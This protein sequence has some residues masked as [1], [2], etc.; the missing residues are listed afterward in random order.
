MISSC[1]YK[2]LVTCCHQVAVDSFNCCL[3]ELSHPSPSSSVVPLSCQSVV[4]GHGTRYRNLSCFV[5]DGSGD[6]EGSLVDEELCSSLELAV[7][8]DKQIRLK[9][10]CVL[11]CPGNTAAQSVCSPWA[12]CAAWATWQSHAQTHDRAEAVCHR[13]MYRTQ[14]RDSFTEMLLTGCVTSDPES[15][16]SSWNW[17]FQKHSFNVAVSKTGHTV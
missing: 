2:L 15:V 8:G 14:E 5:S 7:D 16:S 12:S 10:A 17:H 6:G 9:E 4:C 1:S 3:S 13:H 11:P